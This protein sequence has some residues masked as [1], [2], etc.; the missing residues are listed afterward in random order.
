MKVIF[1][2]LQI[3]SEDWSFMKYEFR[4]NSFVGN[5]YNS[6]IYSLLEI[7]K[8]GSTEVVFFL[9]SIF[10]VCALYWVVSCLNIWE[11]SVWFDAYFNQI[12]LIEDFLSFKQIS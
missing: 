4:R 5:W 12:L 6:K 11:H 8:D 10:F 7:V 2:R 3:S 1:F 9:K